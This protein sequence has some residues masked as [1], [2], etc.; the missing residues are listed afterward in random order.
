MGNMHTEY[1]AM[2]TAIAAYMKVLETDM[3]RDCKSEERVDPAHISGEWVA[4][5][6]H[7]DTDAMNEVASRV[8]A[9][10][11][12]LR[13][14][15]RMEDDGN[16]VLSLAALHD[17]LAEGSFM[18]LDNYGNEVKP[19]CFDLDAEAAKS[20]RAVNLC[21]RLNDL[22]CEFNN[23]DGEFHDEFDCI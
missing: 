21:N 17:I 20:P 23:L 22:L 7:A 5:M 6:L 12:N 19:A 2:I 15:P 9:H 18:V 8:K 11:L 4:D 10:V 13:R 3:E 16:C 14:K 1:E